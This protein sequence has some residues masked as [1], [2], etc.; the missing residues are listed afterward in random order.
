MLGW[1]QGDSERE[2]FG[3]KKP[4]ELI[5]TLDKAVKFLEKKKCEPYILILAH[6]GVIK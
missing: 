3:V 2:P 6:E 5:N 1:A 4:V